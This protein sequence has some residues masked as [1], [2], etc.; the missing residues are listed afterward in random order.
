MNRRPSGP[1]DN[2]K[3]PRFKRHGGFKRKVCRFCVDKVVDI[4][5]KDISLLQNYM[6]E[7]GKLIAARVTGCCAKHQRILTAAIKRARDIALLPYTMHY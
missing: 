7:R 1:A 6:T 3:N 2:K 5:Y 4:D